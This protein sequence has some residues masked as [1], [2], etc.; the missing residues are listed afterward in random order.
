MT[1]EQVNESVPYI[2]AV[3]D[4]VCDDAGC[5]HG[6]GVRVVQVGGLVPHTAVTVDEEEFGGLRGQQA[7]EG[8]QVENDIRERNGLRRHVAGTRIDLITTSTNTTVTTSDT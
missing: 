6:L 3:D 5:D 4:S 2:V 7:V 1:C 8:P